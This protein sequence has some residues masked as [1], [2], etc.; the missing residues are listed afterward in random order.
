MITAR[1]FPI[2]RGWQYHT[3]HTYIYIY[4]IQPYL[5]VWILVIAV[6]WLRWKGTWAVFTQ[7]LHPFISCEQQS[8]EEHKRWQRSQIGPGHLFS[9]GFQHVYTPLFWGKN[10]L[11]HR[12][13]VGLSLHEG[14]TGERHGLRGKCAR[15]TSSRS[16]RLRRCLTIKLGGLSQTCASVGTHANHGTESDFCL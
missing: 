4:T 14:G 13:P 12:P 6:S 1:E 9:K 2:F 15:G 10:R 7:V 16:R 11:S 8:S 3:I 5:H